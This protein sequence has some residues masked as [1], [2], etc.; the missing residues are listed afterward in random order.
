MKP[1]WKI[2]SFLKKKSNINLPHDPATPFF[3]VYPGEME[4]RVHTRT[5]THV[6]SSTVHDSK[7]RDHQGWWSGSSSKN[8]CLASVRP[9]LN[10]SAA[11]K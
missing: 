5:Y 3:A 9:S 2:F 1:C 7:N 8:T 10:P 4:T 6:L 11:K